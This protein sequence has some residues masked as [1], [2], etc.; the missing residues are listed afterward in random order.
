MNTRTYNKKASLII[1]LAKVILGIAFVVLVK[2]TNCTV[3]AA[4]NI[5][6][7]ETE[8]EVSEQN[9]EHSIDNAKVVD[10]YFAYAEPD[11][12]FT[13][14]TV[15]VGIIDSGI[16][17]DDKLSDRI[18]DNDYSTN[19]NYS[20]E[21]NHGTLIANTIASINNENV[22]IKSYKVTDD[23]NNVSEDSLCEALEKAIE[24]RVDIINISII[25]KGYSERI[26][27]LIN[28]ADKQGIYVVVSSGNQGDNI[29]NYIPAGL[30]NVISVGAV[31]NSNEIESYS[32]IGKGISY[33]ANGSVEYT[34][35]NGSI[36]RITGTSFASAKV[37][38][39]LAYVISNSEKIPVEVLDNAAKKLDMGAEGYDEIYGTGVITFENIKEALKETHSDSKLYITDRNKAIANKVYRDSSNK[40][41]NKNELLGIGR[42]QLDQ[43]DASFGIEIDT[44]G[45]SVS[46]EWYYVHDGQ[47]NKVTNWDNR[48]YEEK[49]TYNQTGITAYYSNDTCY[50]HTDD[51]GNTVGEKPFSFEKDGNTGKVSGNF[52]RHTPYIH[53]TSVTPPDSHRHLESISDNTGNMVTGWWNSSDRDSLSGKM[54]FNV[55]DCGIY[56][57]NWVGDDHP[58]EREDG[59][60][61]KLS[62]NWG[63]DTHTMTIKT[64]GHC[65][66]SGDGT[67]NH[68]ANAKTK[69]TFDEGYELDYIEYTK[70]GEAST[71]LTQYSFD[72]DNS[73]GKGWNYSM[74]DDRTMKVYCKKKTYTQTI[75]YYYENQESTD[76]TNLDNYTKVGS[77]TADVKY[78][79]D[80]TPTHISKLETGREYYK[81]AD[82]ITVTSEN[83][84]NI[85]YSWKRS[86]IDID[87]IL[88][89]DQSTIARTYDTMGKR[90]K[91]KVTVVRGDNTTISEN[92][93]EDWCQELKYCDILKIYVANGVRGYQFTGRVFKQAYNG[94]QY[95]WN[96]HTLMNIN[97]STEFKV[98][99]SG[100]IITLV[101]EKGVGLMQYM[102]GATDFTASSVLNSGLNTG[103]KSYSLGQY[104]V[105]G[106]GYGLGSW[107]SEVIS[108]ST[109]QQQKIDTEDDKFIVEPRNSNFEEQS[110]T[111]HFTRTGYTFN[112]TYTLPNGGTI[113]EGKEYSY[114]SIAGNTVYDINTNDFVSN[115]FMIKSADHSSGLRMWDVTGAV[116]KAGTKVQLHPDNKT[117][118]PA[119][120]WWL[121][122]GGTTSDGKSFYY[123]H[124][125]SS[126][127]IAYE[128]NGSQGSKIVLA[129]LS[130]ASNQKWVLETVDNNPRKYL[131]RTADTT[132][133]LGTYGYIDNI[134]GWSGDQL[135]LYKKYDSCGRSLANQEWYIGYLD[136]RQSVAVANYTAN[137]YTITYDLNKPSENS[138]GVPSGTYTA[139]NSATHEPTMSDNLGVLN[140]DNLQKGVYT[141]QVTYDS[142][143]GTTPT[144]YLQGWVFKGWRD[145]SGETWTSESIWKIPANTTLYAYWEPITYEVRL[146]ANEIATGLKDST[147]YDSL[148]GK[149]TTE[150]KVDLQHKENSFTLG[151]TTWTLKSNSD[152][153]LYYT[154]TFTY[155]KESNLGDY[156]RYFHMRYYIGNGWYANSTASSSTKEPAIEN[157]VTNGAG[158]IATCSFSN[159]DS[160]YKGTSRKWNLTDILNQT[161]TIVSSSNTGYHGVVY[162]I[163]YYNLNSIGNFNAGLTGNNESYFR[164]FYVGQNITYDMLTLMKDSQNKSPEFKDLVNNK[165]SYP[166]TK[167]S[168]T[169]SNLTKP[170]FTDDYQSGYVD[171]Q[172]KIESLVFLNSAGNQVGQTY[173]RDDLI[174][175]GVKVPDTARKY[176]VTFTS[177]DTGWTEARSDFNNKT[178]GNSLSS[179]MVNWSDRYY[180]QTDARTIRGQYTGRI[181]N[182]NSPE[183]NKSIVWIYSKDNSGINE[184]KL[185]DLIINYQVVTDK[186]DS[187]NTLS[188]W[189]NKETASKE[190]RN[191]LTTT[192]K[193]DK[194]EVKNGSFSGKKEQVGLDDIVKSIKSAT[195]NT[196]YDVE[197]K[198]K[199]SFNSNNDNKSEITTTV[200]VIVIVNEK[201][202]IL[203]ESNTQNSLRYLPTEI[204]GMTTYQLDDTLKKNENIINSNK[205]KLGN[206]KETETYGRIQ[207]VEY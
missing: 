129:E 8:N 45:G 123:I 11:K 140:Y 112:G 71:W 192:G 159:T 94:D 69:I 146:E 135:A 119:Q 51:N 189:Y 75:N 163:P 12:L 37:T 158:G 50:R 4:E 169:D 96:N 89:G 120:Q 156:D 202:E 179:A 31:D 80:W 34:T 52:K 65:E 5:N 70:C 66:V 183:I 180:K 6:N 100:A 81:G 118:H 173:T 38:A 193:A 19:A 147:L 21:A 171:N 49:T 185:K 205:N 110:G 77:T 162:L 144:P 102:S 195:S 151:N 142:K 87:N 73:E 182:N 39:Y 121:E 198:F 43:A 207:I 68:G 125:A 27:E 101:Y 7:F 60:T 197:V 175:K 72:F 25:F 22:K 167:T 3:Y 188:N 88:G 93:V 47:L 196:Y 190:L 116:Y 165:L 42:L 145:I 58:T 23:K 150:Y 53:I 126:L 74:A 113:T 56:L 136:D 124:N 206:S 99:D 164:R 148:D 59:V 54:T 24:D 187:D 177:Q 78:D 111:N 117:T 204:T 17:V 41:L 138:K 203:D 76:K 166:I 176:V 16:N 83:T 191:S 194:L 67:Y 14:K 132:S 13:G 149:V 181:E 44:N 48:F 63:W 155:D 130:G 115:M 57:G 200:R 64:D 178:Y 103:V 134:N 184:A 141:Q 26:E 105:P 133:G 95:D 46:W 170:S 30:K 92:Y 2:D 91:F 186:E 137:T 152:G 201:E 82:N 20:D 199:D 114:N 1:K 55:V 154:S 85:Y 172:I 90:G 28:K 153:S 29:D 160:N 9:Y 33:T 97:S 127:V 84:I 40:E 79:T 18:I 98:G 35:K 108:G 174:G 143:I 139:S 157:G 131:I 32:N 86:T 122:S 161:G 15:K 36:K 107:E 62:L 104:Y 109:L 10:G 106:N 168:Y 128:G 61:Y